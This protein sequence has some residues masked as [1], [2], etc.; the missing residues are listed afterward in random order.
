MINRIKMAVRDWMKDHNLGLDPIFIPA[1]PV[2]TMRAL[3]GEFLPG[4]VTVLY[5]R[6]GSFENL[7][8]PE[9]GGGSSHLLKDFDE[10]VLQSFNVH[11][12]RLGPYEIGV[13]EGRLPTGRR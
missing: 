1:S 2:N 12:E 13:F 6:F 7:F 11:M 8:S 4:L 5:Y 3:R 10:E 9:F